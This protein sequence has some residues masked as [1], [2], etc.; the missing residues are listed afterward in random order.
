MET[1]MEHEMETGIILGLYWVY[2]GIMENQMETTTY[3][4]VATSLPLLYRLKVRRTIESFVAFQGLKSG[5]PSLV[6]SLVPSPRQNIAVVK[7][8]EAGYS[9]LQHGAG[10]RV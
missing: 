10:C 8:V 3:F 5:D 2:I 1:K 4:C 7:A 9:S 6:W